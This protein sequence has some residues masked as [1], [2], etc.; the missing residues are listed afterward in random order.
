MFQKGAFN[1]LKGDIAVIEMEEPGVYRQILTS[2][3]CSYPHLQ[4]RGEPVGNIFR[5]TVGTCRYAFVFKPLQHGL[6]HLQD[7]LIVSVNVLTMSL[8]TLWKIIRL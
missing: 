8:Q 4:H 3:L 7:F 5:A 1:F 6:I 2:N